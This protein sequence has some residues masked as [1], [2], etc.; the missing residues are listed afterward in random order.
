MEQSPFWEA[1]CHI[2]SEESLSFMDPYGS[3][4]YSQESATS[5]YPEPDEFSPQLP[6]IFP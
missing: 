2:A 5:T 3:L 6:N 4:T 1:S